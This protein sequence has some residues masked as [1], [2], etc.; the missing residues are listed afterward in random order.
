MRRLLL[1]ILL[2]L[3]VSLAV[4]ESTRLSSSETDLPV[5]HDGAVVSTA[6]SGAQSVLRD[7]EA[8]PSACSRNLAIVTEIRARCGLYV[9]G[10]A[11]PSGQY[12]GG[13]SGSECLWFLYTGEL[14][15]SVQVCKGDYLDSLTFTTNVRT[16][17]FPDRTTGGSCVL[18]SAAAGQTLVNFQATASSSSGHYLTSFQPEWGFVYLPAGCVPTPASIVPVSSSCDPNTSLRNPNLL[19]SIRAR[20][21]S[22]VDAI[23]M[24]D[25]QKVGGNGGNEVT[26]SLNNNEVINAVTIC[27]GNYLDSLTF[28]T[29]IGNSFKIPTASTGG[30]CRESRAASGQGLVD[31]QVESSG[32]YLTNFTAIWES[33]QL[34]P[35][36]TPG[37]TSPRSN[38][39]SSSSDASPQSNPASMLAALFMAVVALLLM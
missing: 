7:A 25:G 39:S 12:V 37:S 31:F 3:V 8:I 30:V 26:V 33:I 24:P 20:V 6:S 38:S 35:C 32:A 17:K 34:Y 10:I 23:Y 1:P 14:I 4:S 13:S 2:A 28:K 18:Y 11:L 22:Y 27:V 5:P 16:V 15:T 36:A 19:T 9:D 21:G 29:D